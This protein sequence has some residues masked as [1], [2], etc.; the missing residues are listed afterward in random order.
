MIMSRRVFAAALSLTL[1]S[2]CSTTTTSSQGS[3]APKTYTVKA[4]QVQVAEGVGKGRYEDP[5]LRQQALATLK[6]EL[7]KAAASVPGGSKAAT[8]QIVLTEMQLKTSGARAFGGV[9]AI[10]GTMKIVDAQGKTLREPQ[11]VRYWDQA[12][13]NGTVING[14]PI[15]LIINASRNNAA[16]QSGEDQ[17]KLFSGFAAAVQSTLS[18]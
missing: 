4:V 6:T 9:N 10:G 15:G 16:Q 7:T 8:A 3:V 18:K 1:I 2:A 13:N 17:A 14:L 12:K 11:A 5:A